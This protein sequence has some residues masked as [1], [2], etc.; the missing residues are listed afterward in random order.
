MDQ[1]FSEL[2]KSD[3]SPKDDLDSILRSSLLPVSCQC[4]G[5]IL[6]SYT[7]GDRLE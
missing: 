6:V 7:R 2:G 1:K 3:K 4:G 5:S